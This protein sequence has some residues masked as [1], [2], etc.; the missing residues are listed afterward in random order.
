M[1][2]LRNGSLTKDS[3]LFWDEPEANL[4]PK[5]IIEVRKVLQ[6]LAK[7]G[8]QIFI[9]THDYLLGFELSLLAEYLSDNPNNIKFFSLYKP[10]IKSGV[11]VESGPTL[12]HIDHNSI[13]QEFASHHDREGDLFYKD[14]SGF[15]N[16]TGLIVLIFLKVYIYYPTFLISLY[17][18]AAVFSPNIFSF[19]SK[20]FT[21][22]V[23]NY[24][25]DYDDKGDGDYTKDRDIWQK[26]Y[27]VDSL[28]EAIM[29]QN[30]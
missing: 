11:I 3:I 10:S 2:L 25:T 26:E 13:L 21:M 9:T 20:S 1:Y 24:K 22:N 30:T 29:K 27:T 18:S 28:F 19:I 5:L 6:A 8:M 16:L 4:N 12:A 17:I 23:A 14:L 7:T 15:K